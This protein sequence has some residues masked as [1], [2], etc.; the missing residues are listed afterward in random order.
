MPGTPG[1]FQVLMHQNLSDPANSTQWVVGTT[2]TLKIDALDQLS[3]GTFVALY[4]FNL[5]NGSG[6][7]IV[8]SGRGTWK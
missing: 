3:D 4:S 8:G 6:G 2:G 7:T 1:T 5:S